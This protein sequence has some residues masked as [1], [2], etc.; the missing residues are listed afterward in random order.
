MWVA[1]LFLLLIIDSE[2]SCQVCLYIY[3]AVVFM[4]SSHDL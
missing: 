4:F 2:L 1:E 3:H